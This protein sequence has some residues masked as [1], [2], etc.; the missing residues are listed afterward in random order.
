MGAKLTRAALEYRY[1]PFEGGAGTENGG[2]LCPVWN[3]YGAASA[4]RTQA[5]AR[6][7]FSEAAPAAEGQELL[8]ASVDASDG[9]V[10]GE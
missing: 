6:S 3:F 2:L 7:I 8:L 1:V 4:A 9:R 5:D 10:Y